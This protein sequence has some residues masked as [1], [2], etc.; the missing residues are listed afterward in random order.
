MVGAGPWHGAPGLSLQQG[1]TSCFSFSRV[2]QHDVCPLS[3]Q[4]SA[5]PDSDSSS[6]LGTSTG[7][8]VWLEAQRQEQTCTPVLYSSRS[9]QKLHL[10][11]FLELFSSS[12]V[13]FLLCIFLTIFASCFTVQAK[14]SISLYK[15]KH[16]F[17]I[18]KEGWQMKKYFPHGNE[19]WQFLQH[20]DLLYFFLR[21]WKWRGQERVC[22]SRHRFSDQRHSLWRMEYWIPFAVSLFLSTFESGCSLWT[23]WNMSIPPTAALPF[24]PDTGIFKGHDTAWPEKGG[25]PKHP[26]PLLTYTRPCW[27]I[28][29]E[30]GITLKLVGCIFSPQA[31]G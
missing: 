14:L 9:I 11:L 1:T 27:K 31:H 29:R 18:R 8:M 4:R 26:W 2:R 23:L 21:V 22:L 5:S 25:A 28:G 10:Q 19:G 12:L 13:F 24:F 30:L 3:K 20:S 15:N 16:H 17:V 7:T 6:C